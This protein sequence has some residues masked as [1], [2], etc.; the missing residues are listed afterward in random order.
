MAV[1]HAEPVEAALEIEHVDSHLHPEG[2]FDVA[3]HPVPTGREEI[4]RFT[5]LRRLRGLHAD[6]PLD[7]GGSRL[8]FE[9]PE[10]VRAEVVSAV[11]KPVGTQTRRISIN[12]GQI[13]DRRRVV[14][15]DNCETE[16]YA[17]I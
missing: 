16:S 14:S 11:G 17:P 9:A 15:D 1:T 12:A 6:A 10:G 8:K 7:G 2:S 3:E 4:W 13:V 5:P